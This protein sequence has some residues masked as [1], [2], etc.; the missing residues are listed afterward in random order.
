MR[1]EMTVTPNI[2]VPAE[3]MRQKGG[4]FFVAGIGRGVGGLPMVHQAEMCRHHVFT[5]LRNEDVGHAAS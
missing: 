4:A 1:R 3:I 5:R 2:V